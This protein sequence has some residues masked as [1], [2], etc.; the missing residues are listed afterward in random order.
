MIA[1][2]CTVRPENKR[3]YPRRAITLDLSKHL[4][5]ADKKTPIHCLGIDISRSGLRVV[6]FESFSTSLLPGWPV[7]LA[8]NGK[9]IPLEVVWVQ[10]S[11]ERQDVRRVGLMTKDPISNLVKEFWLDREAKNPKAK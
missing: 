9:A 11:S 1:A 6:C 2:R 10:T 3:K 5:G 7:Y 4:V 8:V